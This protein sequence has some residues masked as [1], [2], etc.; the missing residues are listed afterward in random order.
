MEVGTLT[1]EKRK[2]KLFPRP[3]ERM[4]PLALQITKLSQR[5]NNPSKEGTNNFTTGGRL[6]KAQVKRQR[7]T[8]PKKQSCI[9]EMNTQN[10]S[11][12]IITHN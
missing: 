10:A 2:N 12:Y 9:L 3:L 11:L 7:K 4:E 1:I 6:G 5:K 8:T